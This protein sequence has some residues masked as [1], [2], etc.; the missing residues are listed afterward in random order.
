MANQATTDLIAADRLVGIIQQMAARQ[1]NPVL[2]VLG[3][4]IHH[5]QQEQKYPQPPLDFQQGPWRAFYHCHTVTDSD[6]NEHGHFHVFVRFQQAWLHVAALSMDVEGQ[7]QAWLAVNRW[8]TDGPWLPAAQ[9]IQHLETIEYDFP[10]SSLLENWLL[11][12]LQVFAAEINSLLESRDMTLSQFDKHGE[13]SVLLE[14]R[15]IYT[16]AIHNINLLSK[17]NSLYPQP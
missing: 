4:Q 11:N 7:P 15:D 6:L 16:L 13:R 5:L 8:V 2:E 10:E 3:D 17:L 1:T 14:N 9:L 12:M